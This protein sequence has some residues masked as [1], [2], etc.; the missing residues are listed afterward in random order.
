M[1]SPQ[2]MDLRKNNIEPFPL[3]LIE[4]GVVLIGN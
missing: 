3:P 1:D 2:A 4:G